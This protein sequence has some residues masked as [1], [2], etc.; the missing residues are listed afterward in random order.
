MGIHKKLDAIQKQN[1]IIND[2]NEWEYTH[3]NQH[4]P[5]RLFCGRTE[6]SGKNC[7]GWQTAAPNRTG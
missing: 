3:N 1:C 6:M 7:S 5:A 4:P 2:R